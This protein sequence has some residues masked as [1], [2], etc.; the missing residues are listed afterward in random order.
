MAKRTIRKQ[1]SERRASD[2]SDTVVTVS[3]EL[4]V[5]KSADADTVTVTESYEVRADEAAASP[6]DVKKKPEKKGFLDEYKD[7][8]N[9][10]KCALYGIG[11]LLSALLAFYIRIIPRDGVFMENGFIR[12][13][14]NDPWYHWR[15]VDYLLQN[16]P[17]FLWFD[18]ATTYPYG[19]PQAFAPLYDYIL[20]AAIKILQFLTGNTTEAYAMTIAAYWPCV[21][22][23]CCVVVVYFVAKKLFDS[24][25]VGLMSAFLLAVAPG[26]FLSRSI[27]G[28]NDHHVAEVL[29]SSLVILF[30]IFTLLKARDKNITF[31]EISK[32]N[33]SAFKPILPYAV[34][35]G[36]A[37]A[38]YT[39]V[40]EGA[41]LFAFIIGV[42]ITVQMMINHLKGEGTAFIAATGIIIFAIDFLIVFITP[43]IGEY[44]SLHMMALGAGIIAMILMAVLSYALEKK[45]LNKLYYPG[46]LAG[47][48][49]VAAAVGSIVSSTVRDALLGIVSFFTRTGGA[50]TIGEASPYFGS[51]VNPLLFTVL[52]AAF[53]IILP[54]MATPYIKKNSIKK[55]LLAGWAILFFLL[56]LASGSAFN[57]FTTF[58]VMG[59]IWIIVLPIMAYIAVKNNSMEKTLLVVW[60]LL[61]LWALVQQNRFSYYFVVPVIILTSWAFMEL[62]RAVKADEAWTLFKKNYLSKEG[63]SKKEESAPVYSSHQERAKSK[64]DSSKVKAKQ[65]DNGNEKI[66]LASVVL[67]V[68]LLVLLVPTYTMTSQYVAG[69]GGPNE[70]W[71]ETSLWIRDNTPE[72]GLDWAGYYEEPLQD[73]DGDGVADTVSGIG[74]EHFENQASIVPFDYPGLSYGVLSWW[75]YGHWLEVIGERTVNANPFQFGVGGR[76]GNATDEMIPG[77][78]PFF[79][80]ETE[81]DATGYLIDIDPREDKVGARYVVTDIEM[82]SGMSKFYA[83]TAWTL[84]TEDYYVTYNINGN[85]STFIGSDRYFNSMVYRLHMQDAVGLEQY[86]MVYESLIY[87][88]NDTMSRQE[89]FY[90]QLFNQIYSQSVAESNTG[91]VKV[92]EYVEGA[93][94]KGTAS[95]NETVELTLTIQTNQNRIFNYNQTVKAD[96]NG[97]FSFRVPYSTTG[98]V[99]GETNFAVKPIGNYTVKYGS[100]EERIDVSEDDVLNGKTVTV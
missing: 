39:L 35:T 84:D 17:D 14:E 19:T 49:V 75:D 64:R 61:L 57:L 20:A 53:L 25:N 69:T 63:R 46:I 7:K 85:N 97:N 80:A 98:S 87:N 79:V 6:E 8:N 94:I 16:F 74:I 51:S 38:A 50:T 81:K 29:F 77:A 55:G 70:A 5:E 33:L 28:F 100:V 83:M 32:G 27:I 90:K 56:I 65:V 78:A 10:I 3:E 52:I 41:L 22:A 72:I 88:S 44:K 26:Q 48:V 92:F 36:I 89:I 62:A 68:A 73:I 4:T 76:R 43:Q 2:D 58:S 12:F 95:A 54:F 42:F 86:R 66:V 11:V 18:P 59:Y 99:N 96:E 24:R 15:N 60:S 31:E 91:Y 93:V 30:L 21:L 23:A 67:V 34:L 45:D 9:L 82:A 71:I 40:W 47:L 13:G 1:T 37:M